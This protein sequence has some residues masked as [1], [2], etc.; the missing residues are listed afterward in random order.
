[1]TGWGEGKGQVHRDC[2]PLWNLRAS[3]VTLI[4]YVLYK[5][6]YE[7]YHKF[8]NRIINLHLPILIISGRVFARMR[9]FHTVACTS[10]YDP[11]RRFVGFS[12]VL[13]LCCSVGG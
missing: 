10:L 2:V 9:L 1:M 5:L 8:I 3:V 7:L 11:L 12:V 6:C 13:L 4:H